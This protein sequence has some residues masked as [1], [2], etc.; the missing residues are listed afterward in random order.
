[1]NQTLA[2]GPALR[3]WPPSELGLRKRRRQL[4]CVFL[5]VFQLLVIIAQFFE[6][7]VLGRR[8][9][10]RHSVTSSCR[11]STSAA[12]MLSCRA[13]TNSGTTKPASP[14]LLYSSH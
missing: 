5:D 7:C 8:G 14:L 13:T 2:N 4:Q 12:C 11:Y 3:R 10:C 1:M 9:G 6:Q